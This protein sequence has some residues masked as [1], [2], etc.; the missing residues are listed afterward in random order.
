MDEI[1]V[2]GSRGAPNALPESI[3]LLASG[4]IH[5]KPLV[6]HRLPLSEAQRGM[7]IFSNRLENVIRVV[8]VP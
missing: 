3:G 4:R 7:E 1:D 8:L 5:V 2:A 6:T